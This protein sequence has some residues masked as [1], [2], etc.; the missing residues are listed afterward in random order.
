[1]WLECGGLLADGV[2]LNAVKCAFFPSSSSSI[3]LRVLAHFA[4]FAAATHEAQGKEVTIML[5]VVVQR[6]KAST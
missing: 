1:M 5:K 4:L 3:S 2:F 6:K